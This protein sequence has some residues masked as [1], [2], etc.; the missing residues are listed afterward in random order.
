MAFLGNLY[1]NLQG[2]P[3][4]RAYRL[5]EARKIDR[6]LDLLQKY[7]ESHPEHLPSRLLTAGLFM[8]EGRPEDAAEHLRKAFQHDPHGAQEIRLLVDQLKLPKEDHWPIYL[9]EGE[10]R[11][12]RGELSEALQLIEAIPSNHRTRWR[13]RRLTQM[14]KVF[15]D[16]KHLPLSSK[17]LMAAYFAALSQESLGMPSEAAETYQVLLS[18]CP[19]EKERISRR[20]E[21]LLATDYRNLDL[22]LSL[23]EIQAALGNTEQAVREFS[24]AL[25]LD[26][27]SAPA[28]AARLQVLLK[29]HKDNDGLRWVFLQARST[30]GL[31][32]EVLDEIRYLTRKGSYIQDA[33]H[34]LER[35]LKEQFNP[36]AALLVAGLYVRHGRATDALEWIYR[37]VNQVGEDRLVHAY[38]DVIKHRPDAAQ[39]YLLLSDLHLRKGEFGQAM[40]VLR[41]LMEVDP[42]QDSLILSRLTRFV[43]RN[44]NHLGALRILGELLLRKGEE[45]KAVII[46][47]HALR[48]CQKGDLETRKSLQEHL[49]KRPDHHR[50]RL[51]FA[52]ALAAENRST[53]ALRELTILAEKAPSLAGE[54]L[55]LL[56]SLS[57]RDPEL[58]NG[59]LAVYQLLEASR[60]L[61]DAVQFGMAQA[62]AAAG[63]FRNALARYR[64]S[65]RKF[66]NRLNAIEKAIHRL[67]ETP[68][69]A[70]EARYVLA[71]IALA[72]GEYEAASRVLRFAGLRNPE[73]FNRIL[74]F[75]IKVVSREP[76]NLQA[77]IGLSGAYLVGKYYQRVLALGQETLAL[78]DDEVSAPVKIDMGDARREMGD[79]VGAVKTYYSAFQSREELA[80]RV[81]MTLRSILEVHPSESLAHLALGRILLHAAK[82][83]EGLDA[84]ME[85]RRLDPQQSSVVLGHLEQLCSLNPTVP[86]IPLAMATIYRD[87][88]EN[89]K[90]IHVLSELLDFSPRVAPKVVSELKIILE[91]DRDN[92]LGWFHLGRSLQLIGE[93][94]RAGE[95]YLK[96]FQGDS[97]LGPRILV[98]LRRL[99]KQHPASPGISA[100]MSRILASNGKWLEAAEWLQKAIQKTEGSTE[101]FLKDLESLA[102]RLPDHPQMSLILATEFGRTG[103]IGDALECYE[104]VLILNPSLHQEIRICV[105]H[106][107]EP[108]ANLPRA[109]LLRS[110]AWAQ[111]G[112]SREAL[113]D[114]RE[115]SQFGATREQILALGGELQQRFPDSLGPL[116]HLVDLRCA[117]GEWRQAA[118]LLE[119]ASDAGWK[120]GE[121]LA[122]LLRAWRVY[123]SLGNQKQAL[124]ALREAERLAPERNR[125]LE[126]IHTFRIQQVKSRAKDLEDGIRNQKQGMEDL[127]E[128]IGHLVDLGDCPRG[129]EILTEFRDQLDASTYARLAASVYDRQGQHYRALEI[130]QNKGSPVDLAL[131]AEKCGELSLAAATLEKFVGTGEESWTRKRLEK[132]Y[133]HLTLQDLDRG[134]EKIIG[135]TTVLF[136]H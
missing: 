30:L 88:G 77:R 86:F 122:V 24:L 4:A 60:V 1:R 11:I 112:K 21:A 120:G 87:I 36:E 58:A 32:K 127:P 102:R 135:E 125:F 59:S 108:G 80:P 69:A 78:Q 111:E 110:R 73:E 15:Q 27:S 19:Q 121:K 132:Y 117:A 34:L 48:G 81:M 130:L 89:K 68:P 114:L 31:G 133:L 49:R 57:L 65:C 123:G 116:I 96:A 124:N 74:G 92:V 82:V 20:M 94:A 97:Q 90:A 71:E 42:S 115:A 22:R 83:E 23:G 63:H 85:A 105:S 10:F 51:G 14:R 72:R 52:E 64:Q 54:F 16:E 106:F 99:G 29:E 37:A 129:L 2:D 119:G 95:A 104:R 128:L 53:E 38:K 43:E 39:A 75:L 126:S 131:A 44:R 109:Y 66:P 5:R 100:T 9:A 98:L 56:S 45:G 47:R 101:A 50:L 33:I 67:A 107:L 40:E 28:L 18:R 7:L 13:D 6:A 93:T 46:L 17:T 103:R 61:P 113:A 62:E 91:V 8:E 136:A 55:H 41:T 134:S 118:Q 70:A 26:P 76:K 3:V 25:E 79:L 35:K 84:L 12:R